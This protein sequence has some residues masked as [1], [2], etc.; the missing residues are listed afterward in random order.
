MKKGI[1]YFFAGVGITLCLAIIWSFKSPADAPVSYTVVN[2]YGGPGRYAVTANTDGIAEELKF[3][4]GVSDPQV[5]IQITSK[6]DAKGYNLDHFTMGLNG[7]SPTYSL[8]FKK[9]P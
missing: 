6:M 9:K 7:S 2:L 1:L 4:K 5:I 8:I 3:D